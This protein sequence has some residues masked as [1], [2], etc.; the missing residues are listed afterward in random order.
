MRDR[1]REA[2]YAAGF[3]PLCQQNPPTGGAPTGDPTP[4]PT[5]GQPPAGGGG[6]PPATPPPGAPAGFNPADWIPRTR[7]DEVSEENRRLKKAEE[8]RVAAEAQRKGDFETLSKTEKEKR[9]AAEAKALRIARRGTFIARAAGKVVDAEA[10]Y[11]LAL[12]AGLLDDIEVDDEGNAVKPAK[13]DSA[14]EEI[15]KRNEFL[16]PTSGPNPRSFG[17]PK[18]G[19]EPNPGLDP[20]KMDAR[21]MLREGYRNPQPRR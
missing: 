17:E 6:T 21:D 8:D 2:I 4:S 15:V 16:K 11:V 12:A 7:L 5:S 18:G 19:T 10:A 13:V 20:S 1:L 14:V 9:E 3:G